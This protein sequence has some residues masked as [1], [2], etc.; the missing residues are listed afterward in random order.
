[1]GF[2]ESQKLSIWN[3]CPRLLRK[4]SMTAWC[5][6]IVIHTANTAKDL[7]R[8]RSKEFSQRS[9]LPHCLLD[10]QLLPIMANTQ[11]PESWAGCMSLLEIM[12]Q[13]WP[14]GTYACNEIQH[15]FMCAGAISTWYNV[16]PILSATRIHNESVK[17][18]RIQGIISILA[19]LTTEYKKYACG[20]NLG[21]PNDLLCI[22]R[23]GSDQLQTKCM[24]SRET[25]AFYMSISQMADCESKWEDWATGVE[26]SVRAQTCHLI[27]LAER[28]DFLSLLWSPGKLL[29]C[30]DGQR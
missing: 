17:M 18:C 6:E 1:M 20:H 29:E 8:R 26:I 7:P 3:N 24:Y 12:D 27:T 21:F 22:Q 2:T 15:G 19:E 30:E 28:C 14:P 11:D 5:K 23:I 4:W 10:N 13:E 16:Q 25:R 9:W